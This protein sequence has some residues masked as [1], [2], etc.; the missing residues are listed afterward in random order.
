M[1]DSLILVD[2]SYLIY[3]CWYSR[4]DHPQN[5]VSLMRHFY[6]CV[7]DIIKYF[8]SKKVIFAIDS[9]Y[10]T[11]RHQIDS[12][13]KCGRVAMPTAFKEG[14]LLCYK[15]LT[16]LGLTT[17]KVGKYEADDVIG[18]LC[19]HFCDEQIIIITGDK[20]LC[21]LITPNVKIFNWFKNQ[22][23]DE[24]FVYRKFG[25]K[26]HQIADY[27]ALVGDNADAIP[28]VR[29]IGPM[30]ASKLLIQ[31]ESFNNLLNNLHLVPSHLQPGFNNLDQVRQQYFLTTIVKSLPFDYT[32][33]DI[34][35]KSNPEGLLIVQAIFDNFG[36]IDIVRDPS[37]FTS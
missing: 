3:T 23:F 15:I 14:R 28:G 13:Y 35:I 8:K 26:P 11:I 1:N 16:Y 20:D 6:R 21:Q 17:C 9:E 4:G 27:L 12:Q 22:W 7:L 25:V 34:Y 24:D 31:F 2:T 10:P 29:G 18:S 33:E 32:L 19:E 5:Q 30:N 36:C 37:T